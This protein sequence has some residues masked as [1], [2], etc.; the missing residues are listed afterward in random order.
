MKRVAPALRK[1]AV[2]VNQ[3]KRVVIVKFADEPLATQA[4]MAL[5][6]WAEFWHHPKA[7]AA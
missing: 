1:D 5:D 2:Q 6:G 3:R 7:R 4:S